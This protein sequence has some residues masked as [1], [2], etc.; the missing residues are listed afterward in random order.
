[1][2]ILEINKLSKSEKVPIVLKGIPI[3]VKKGGVLI[4]KKKVLHLFGSPHFIPET[5]NANI[6]NL[7]IGDELFV[8]DLNIPKKTCSYSDELDVVVKCKP[9]NDVNSKGIKPYIKNK[10]IKTILTA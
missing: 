8:K 10:K 9:A 5:L 7:D 1:M 2:Y 3:G 6:A 4:V